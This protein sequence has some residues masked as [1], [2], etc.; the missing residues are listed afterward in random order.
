LG[1]VNLNP[2]QTTSFFLKFLHHI[3]DEQLLIIDY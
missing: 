3:F 2:L 1:T